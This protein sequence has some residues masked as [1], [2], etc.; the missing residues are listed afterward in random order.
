MQPFR[1]C[2][3]TGS[4]SVNYALLL[5]LRF[6]SATLNRQVKVT[7]FCDFRPPLNLES[8]DVPNFCDS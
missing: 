5:V 1:D 3:E 6:L 4:L 7:G 8:G 2:S